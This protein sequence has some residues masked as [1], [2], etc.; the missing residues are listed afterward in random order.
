MHFI[1]NLLL[2]LLSLYVPAINLFWLTLRVMCIII[3]NL[4]LLQDSD[5]LSRLQQI[6]LQLQAEVDRLSTTSQSLIDDAASKQTAIQVYIF[7]SSSLNN[8][9]TYDLSIALTVPISSK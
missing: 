3:I 9:R 2:I 7:F 4:S 8:M 5:A 6:L 1:F